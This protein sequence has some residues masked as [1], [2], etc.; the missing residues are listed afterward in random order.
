[1]ARQTFF[2][3][4]Y[5]RDIWRVNQIRNIHNV[6]PRAAAGFHD[7]SLWEE[8]KSKS[9]AAIYKLID[10]ALDGTTV[11]VVCIGS[12]TAGRKFINYEIQQSLDRGNGILGL[13]IHHLYSPT[14]PTEPKGE[15]PY[16]LTNNKVP[17]NDYTNADDLAKWIEKAAK[18][19]G[20]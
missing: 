13:R 19:A 16:K 8:A 17:I 7:A 5:Q 4:H 20:K 15:A 1:M 14:H 3:F 9:D 10:G 2:S 18:D 6:I 11:T 12:A